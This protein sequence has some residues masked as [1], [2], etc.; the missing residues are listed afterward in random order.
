MS[1]IL[2]REDSFVD[3]VSKAQRGLDLDDAALAV[4]SGCSVSEI[5]SLKIGFLEKI[6]L[7]KVAA[8][9]GLGSN[10]LLALAQSRYVPSFVDD[11]DGLAL[12]N[13]QF[14]DMTVNSFLVWDGGAI[15]IL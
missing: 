8:S 4:R 14:D 7:R 5:A 11:L 3:V 2:P 12:L 1:V 6:A 10:A 9:L 15:F 13:S